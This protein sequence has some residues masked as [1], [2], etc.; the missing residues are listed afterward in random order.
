MLIREAEF[1]DEMFEWR[2]VIDDVAINSL[3]STSDHS[4][5]HGHA[6]ESKVLD[7][8]AQYDTCHRVMT[9]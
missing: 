5:M 8:Y 4:T 2:N 9:R 6:H 3:R 1:R 7:A